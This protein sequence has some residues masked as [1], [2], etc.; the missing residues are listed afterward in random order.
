MEQQ[1]ETIIVTDIKEQHVGQYIGMCKWFNDHKGYGWIKTIDD[2]GKYTGM[3]IYVH[4]SNI[5]PN[6]S[7]YKTLV[8]NEYVSFDIHEIQ[9]DGQTKFEAHYV[10]GIKGGPLQCDNP[11]FR[12][13]KKNEDGF[14]T[15][16]Y[17]AKTKNT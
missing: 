15:V 17:K 2:C 7:N 5:F 13:T 10:T 14:K 9:R 11:L 16:N 4:F 3:D 1:P 12:R 8:N 6:T